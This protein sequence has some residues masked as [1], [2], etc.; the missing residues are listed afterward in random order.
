MK[1]KKQDKKKG[2]QAKRKRG[3]RFCPVIY[4]DRENKDSN[5]EKNQTTN[6]LF[7]SCVAVDPVNRPASSGE[8]ENN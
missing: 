2:Q 3:L 8:E 4:R 1:Q 5:K 7:F 6:S